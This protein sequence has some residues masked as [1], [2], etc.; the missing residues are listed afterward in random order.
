LATPEHVAEKAW[1]FMKLQG[2]R[3]TIRPM[4]GS[5]V[6]VM[7]RWRPSVDPRYQ[8]FDFPRRSLAENRRWF[9]WRSR[10]PARRLYTVEDER[11]HV[12]G[13][14]TLREIDGRHS[15]RLGI[16][17]GADYVSQGYGTEALR[18]FLDYYF[19][20]LGFDLMVL[21]VAATNVRAIRSYRSLGFR[22]VGEHY[23][24][25]N[26]RSF[27]ILLHDPRYRHLRTFLRRNGTGYELLFYDMELS[28]AEWRLLP[29][30]PRFPISRE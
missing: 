28:A 3:V 24:P 16:T 11:G 10:D 20:T 26:H 21:D 4:K 30:G 27:R 13:S 18:R 9:E 29:A 19:G 25:A 5:D 22:T 12:I 17:L 1:A 7:T 2:P 15:A 23:Q 8:A 14:L 6:E